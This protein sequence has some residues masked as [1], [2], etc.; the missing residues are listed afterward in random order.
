[1]K[2]NEINNE[3]IVFFIKNYKKPN[4]NIDAN[5]LSGVN[6]LISEEFNKIVA[7]GDIKFIISYQFTEFKFNFF[8]VLCKYGNPQDLIAAI[9]ILESDEINS[10]DDNRYTGLH[11]AAIAGN[12]ENVKILLQS[13][14]NYNFRS[15]DETR[16][17]LPIHYAC[18]FN[19]REIV[20]ELILSGVD[21]NVKT[22]FG[23]TPL[24]IAAEFGASDVVK[25]LVKIGCDL[26]ATSNSENYN[27]TALHYAVIA[28]SIESV[29]ILA[30]AGANIYLKSL[31]GDDALII[32]C[33]KKF[34]VIVTFLLKFGN[35]NLEEVV[36]ILENN[37]MNHLIYKA[38]DLIFVKD[39]LFNANELR[40][41]AIDLIDY[42]NKV[43]NGN[44]EIFNIELFKNIRVSILFLIAVRQKVGLI[45]KRNIS[46]REFAEKN[47]FLILANS[48]RKL[49]E[50]VLYKQMHNSAKN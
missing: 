43:S 29:E 33:K 37:Q 45:N 36:R 14:A 50:I 41:F 35:D 9:N 46:L 24:H 30:G 8:H 3:I 18:K 7:S 23:L 17:W 47:G 27:L 25:Y 42:L 19:H 31:N 39:K 2:E 13:G 32:A 48:L 44:I 5:L 20:E 4:Y 49:E 6:T 34:E 1:M 21:K 12:Y 40:Y 28:N 26:N 10:Y 22:V 11:H 16:N 38:K 15:S